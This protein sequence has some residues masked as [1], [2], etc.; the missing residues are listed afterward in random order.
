M[1]ELMHFGRY[2]V[3][4]FGAVSVIALSLMLLLPSP[5]QTAAEERVLTAS[6]AATA[7]SAQRKALPIYTAKDFDISRVV[8]ADPKGVPS[9]QP[10]ATPSTFAAPTS[11]ARAAIVVAD[12]VNLRANPSKHGARVGVV[13]AGAA[14]TILGTDRGWT[15]VQTGN[16][17]V[18]WLATKFLQE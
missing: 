2:A 5:Q 1:R 13:G 9:T 7:S 6:A 10:S 14:V 16:G 8:A 3:S 17:D 18:G 15:Q 11:S 4:L 12:A